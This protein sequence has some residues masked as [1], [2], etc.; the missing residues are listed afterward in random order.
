MGA[1]DS[2]AN[3]YATGSVT[4]GRYSYVGGLVGFNY[5]GQSYGASVTD[6]YSTGALSGNIVGGLVGGDW[7]YDD[8]NCYYYTY[9]DTDTSGTTYGVGNVTNEPGITGLTSAQLQSGLPQGFDPKI[10]GQDPKINN[11][12]PYLLANPPQ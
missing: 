7:R 3:S 11:G 10:W 5:A 1:N 4:G 8:C 6:S 2:L 12:L 9:F